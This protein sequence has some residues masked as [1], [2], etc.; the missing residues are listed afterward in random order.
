VTELLTRIQ[1]NQNEFQKAFQSSTI[2][3]ESLSIQID[4]DIVKKQ[5]LE[6]W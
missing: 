5:L 4:K 6:T 2:E 1:N 3:N